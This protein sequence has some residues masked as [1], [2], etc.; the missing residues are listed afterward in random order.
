MYVITIDNHKKNSLMRV[1]IK[2][3]VDKLYL[4]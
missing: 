1:P 3:Q 4:M 2:N